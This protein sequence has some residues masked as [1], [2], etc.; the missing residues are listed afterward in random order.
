MVQDVLGQSAIVNYE[1]TDEIVECGGLRL[2]LQSQV[3]ESGT[4]A[5][6]FIHLNS[7]KEL[8]V[9]INCPETKKA[10]VSAAQPREM[11]EVASNDFA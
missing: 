7:G 2:S 6:A 11:K 4:E 5:V 8:V 9:A 3:P 10:Y 1:V